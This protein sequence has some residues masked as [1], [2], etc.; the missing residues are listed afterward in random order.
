MALLRLKATGQVEDIP[1]AG[2]MDALATGLYEPPGADVQIPV[3]VGGFTGQ[4]AGTGLQYAGDIGA[5]PETEQ[6]FRERERAARIER[7]HGGLLGGAGAFVEQ[8]LDAATLGGFGAVTETIWGEDYT[9]GRRERAEAN[10]LAAGAGAAAGLLAPALLSGGT[11]TAGALARLTPAGAASRLGARIAE[12]G[13]HAGTASLGRAAVGYATE[14]AIYGAGHVL[15]ETILKDKELSAEA[16]LAGA[17]EGAVMGGIGGLGVSLFS[18]GARAAKRRVD[19]LGANRAIAA[20]EAEER[21]AAKEAAKAAK[22]AERAKLEQQRH[23]N[24]I[25][26]EQ[27]R[28]QGRLEAIGARGDTKVSSEVA[29]ADAQ[30]AVARARL[31]QASEALA[32]ERARYETAKMVMDGRLQLSQTY[33]AGWRRA[34]ESREAVAASKLDAAGV[35]ADAKI[36]TGL[37]DALVQSEREDAGYLIEELIPAKMRTEAA[38]ESAKGEVLSRSA[39]LVASTDDLVRQADEIMAV[40]PAAEAELRALRDRAAATT[41]RVTEW[42]ERQTKSLRFQQEN[43]DELRAAGFSTAAPPGPAA[44]AAPAAPGRRMGEI[45]TQTFEVDGAPVTMQG[46]AR[47]L[48]EPEDAA[49]TWTRPAEVSADRPLDQFYVQITMPKESLPRGVPLPSLPGDA[50]IGSVQFAI[51][52]GALYPRKVSVLPEFHRKG[53]ATRMYQ[54]AERETGLK[55]IPAL[56]QTKEGRAFSAAYRARRDAAAAA[57][58]GAFRPVEFK[59]P[60]GVDEHLVALGEAPVKRPYEHDDE[61]ISKWLDSRMP[62]PSA[63]AEDFIALYQNREPK[64]ITPYLRGDSDAIEFAAD[65]TDD[66]FAAYVERQI[67]RRLSMDEAIRLG[68]EAIKASPVP[69]D[70]LLYRSMARPTIDGQDVEWFTKYDKV[71]RPD[72]ASE[73]WERRPVIGDVIDPDPSF[74]STA[75]NLEDAAYYQGPLLVIEMPKGSP[76]LYL[77]SHTN[78]KH[79]FDPVRGVGERNL[80]KLR[81]NENEVLLP[82]NTGFRIKRIEYD[83]GTPGGRKTVF[84]VEPVFANGGPRYEDLASEAAEKVVRTVPIDEMKPNLIALPGQVEGR[85]DAVRAARDAGAA[86]EPVDIHVLPNGKLFV[87]DGRHRLRLAAERGEPVKARF[88]RAA[89]GADVGAEPMFPVAS[90]SEGVPAAAAPPSEFAE[91][92]ETLAA[93]ETAHYELAQAIRPYLDEATGMSLDDAIR[94]MDEAV[95]MQDDIM[96]DAVTRQAEA[97]AV[98]APVAAPAAPAVAAPGPHESPST[99]ATAAAALPAMPPMPGGEAGQL[100]RATA[101]TASAFGVLDLAAALGGLPNTNDI[102]V[103]GPLLGPYLKFRAISGAL[104]RLGIKV[105]GPVARIANT[106]A[107]AQDRAS[108]AIGAIVSG[109]TKAAPALQRGAAPVTNTL[110][111][112][113]WNRDEIEDKPRGRAPQ[114]EKKPSA[115]TLYEKRKEELLLVADDPE[116][117]REELA[118]TIPAPPALATAIAGAVVRKLEWL[119]GLL[120]RETAAPTLRPEPRPASPADIER[121]AVGI[122]ATAD[123]IGYVLG[124]ILRGAVSPLA[125]QALREVFPRLYSQMQAEVLEQVASSEKPLSYNRKRNLSLVF[126]LPLDATLQPEYV[127]ARQEE[128]TAATQAAQPP[129]GGPQLKLSSQSELGPM[130]R[131]MR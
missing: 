72:P 90:A 30:A 61:A 129:A 93:A 5:R 83:V 33:T 56:A 98:A 104:G 41:P 67:G 80:N 88:S 86:M 51:K 25:E 120:P 76:G 2:V 127:A 20:L 3:T 18:R 62:K 44:A 126:D 112:P 63:D 82:R 53:L 38:R 27:L 12:G 4:V 21:V 115:Q 81:A 97:S 47:N 75:L 84:T 117:A 24:R 15:S 92:V 16:F 100:R 54:L 107:T 52:D 106:G 23:L 119:A 32:V 65:A 49:S 105:G 26:M 40:N 79:S 7:E 89:E 71:R 73:P 11:G 60:W 101:P 58:A 29:K 45:V 99:V 69:E 55:V 123:P 95:T 121:L 94:E 22:A 66:G 114:A 116:G 17:G 8:G 124:G 6:G 36:R 108:A 13:A 87:N 35:G 31:E 91:G 109:A 37:A 1:D 48:S 77:N 39:Q 50:K 74:Q 85:A 78:P 68:D 103:I 96:T 34:A 64:Y 42:S 19:A 57:D 59:Q 102:P 110:G 125:V 111:R 131:A 128:W 46:T 10:P 14:G 130:R 9:E 122:A 28:Q 70:V 118:A 43:L 113:L